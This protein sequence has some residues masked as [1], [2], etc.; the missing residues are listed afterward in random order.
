VFKA[1]V[2][3][4][5][6]TLLDVGSLSELGN[7]LFP[8][9]GV[10]LCELWR[11]KQLEYSWLLSL[12]GKYQDFWSLTRLGLQYA[13][14]ALGLSISDTQEERLMQAYLTLPPY[15]EVRT[16]LLRLS[17]RYPL[18]L[19]SNGTPDM[20]ESVVRVNNLETYLSHVLSADEVGVYKPH[21]KVYD[22]VIQAF[23]AIPGEIMFV[24]SNGWEVSGA[25]SFGFSVA[26]CNR[27]GATFETHAPPP[28]LVVENLEG[29]EALLP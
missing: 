4:A 6:G 8:G 29:L 10:A 1:V 24:S 25:K 16:S 13:G 3:D 15:P 27:A 12:M 17:Q 26:W 2:F 28:D 21:P 22:L 7:E 20:L 5:Y 18:A 9:K 19:L 23:F 11:R 14:A